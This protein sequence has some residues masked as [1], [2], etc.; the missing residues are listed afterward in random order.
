MPQLC[1]GQ[2]HKGGIS[3]AS[4][5]LAQ[6]SLAR[7]A[8]HVVV[9]HC[10]I[11]HRIVENLEVRFFN[12]R[13]SSRDGVKFRSS[14]YFTAS[15]LPH[16]RCRTLLIFHNPDVKRA[17]GIRPAGESAALRAAGRALP[18]AKRAAREDFSLLALSRE[19]GKFSAAYP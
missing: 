6:A 1:C 15:C 4:P 11:F 9:F 7:R 13:N 2:P 12:F 3:P 14:V 19:C 17:F 18:A 10:L 8:R 16:F 5:G